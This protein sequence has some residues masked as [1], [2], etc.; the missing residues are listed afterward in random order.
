MTIWQYLFKILAKKYPN[1]AFLVP[2]LDIFGFFCKIL[3][4]DRFEGAD[5]KYDN[6][7]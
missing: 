6:S 7:F 1:K 2:N 4:L 5:L 3:Q